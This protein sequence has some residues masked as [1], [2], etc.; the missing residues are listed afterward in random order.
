MAM[1]ESNGL[2]VLNTQQI[3]SSL[4]IAATTICLGLRRPAFFRRATSAT[5]AGLKRI[6][7]SAGM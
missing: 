6:A 3:T 5:I 7:D 4:R 2:P 1:A